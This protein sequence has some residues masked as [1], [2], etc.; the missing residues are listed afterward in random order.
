M[1]IEA[2]NS[3][4]QAEAGEYLAA[5]LQSERSS[6]EGSSRSASAEGIP[7][8]Y[9]LD[10]LPRRLKWL[11]RSVRMHVVELPAGIPDWV[12]TAR[13]NGIAE[14]D[15]ESKSTL[16]RGGYYLGECFARQPSLRWA[17]GNPE[18]MYCQM[19]VVAGFRGKQ[20]LPPL[21]IFENR[22]ASV[23]ELGQAD[24]VFDSTI[25]TRRKSI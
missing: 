19:P 12:R 11:V 25:R 24:S 5:F 4:T 20:E 7:F 18:F 14:F 2:F 1:R 9:S 17:T 15:E 10:S 13:P 23:I 6:L 21:L 8:D 22:C 16:L 3:M